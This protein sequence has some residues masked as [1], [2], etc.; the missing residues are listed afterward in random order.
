MTVDR[1]VVPDSDLS[2]LQPEVARDAAPGCDLSGLQPWAVLNQ[3]ES[4]QHPNKGHRP[5][6]WGGHS[7]LI[8]PEGV[9]ALGNSPRPKGLGRALRSAGLGRRQP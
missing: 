5:L 3:T 7:L 2:G 6:I 8:H 1:G 9:A 4:L